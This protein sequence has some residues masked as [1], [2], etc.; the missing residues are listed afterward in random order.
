MQINSRPT[1]IIVYFWL[2]SGDLRG[3]WV[4]LLRIKLRTRFTV[5]VRWL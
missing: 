4:W 3:W 5:R 2:Q 1:E